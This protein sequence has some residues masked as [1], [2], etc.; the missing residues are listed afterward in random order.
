MT[1][2]YGN[3]DKDGMPIP[4]NNPWDTPSAP[5]PYGASQGNQ[6]AYQQPQGFQQG[7]QQPQP[8]GQP[9]MSTGY[10]STINIVNGGAPARTESPKS[11]VAAILL[12]FFLGFLGVHNF[13]L[14]RT[15]RGLAQL[16]TW[17][18]SFFAALICGA[19]L[20]LAPLSVIFVMVSAAVGFWA[21]VEF[22]MLIA[23]SG[24]YKYDSEGRVLS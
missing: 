8:Y 19:T 4:G 2:P 3:F 18:G 11:K 23:G 15:G 5:Q 17:S 13:Y 12:A 9:G 16:F 22:I 1:N 24:S 20:I 7:F 21:F 14:G 6:P 10:N